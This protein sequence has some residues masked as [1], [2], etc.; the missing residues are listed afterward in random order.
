MSFETCPDCKM[1]VRHTWF[2]AYCDKCKTELTASKKSRMM[3]T[4]VPIIGF[5]FI[6]IVALE[7]YYLRGQKTQRALYSCFI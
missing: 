3:L 7:E 2:K 5:I 4:L 1:V 6:F